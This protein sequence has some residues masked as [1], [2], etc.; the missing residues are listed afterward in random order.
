MAVVKIW[1]I[2]LELRGACGAEAQCELGPTVGYLSLMEYLRH[3]QPNISLSPLSQ[4]FSNNDIQTLF[5]AKYTFK[6]W[7]FL[8]SKYTHKH[9]KMSWLNIKKDWHL[10]HSKCILIF[11]FYIILFND[12]FDLLHC[13]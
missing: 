12:N 13:F 3:H 5:L 10:G 2:F 9:N 7:V 6:S 8:F 11:L 4:F 1:R